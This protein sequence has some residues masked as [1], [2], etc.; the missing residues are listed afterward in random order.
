[1]VERAW[2]SAVGADGTVI[3]YKPG[4]AQSSLLDLGLTGIQALAPAP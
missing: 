1:M 4:S 3:G 2:W